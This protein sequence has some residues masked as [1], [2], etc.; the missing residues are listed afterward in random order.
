MNSLQEIL[1]NW[2]ENLDQDEWYFSR[3]FEEVTK[4]MTSEEAFHYIPIVIKE[5]TTLQS[6]FLIG[7]LIDFLH[8]VYTKANTTEVHP[9]LLQEQE[10][11]N[12]III[13]YGD[14]Y[15]KHALNEFKKS[16]RWKN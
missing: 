10:N 16:I 9:I 11:I 7:E 5:F 12:E 8:A 4:N 13:T 6:A 15:S 2:Q 14:N 1:I 3:S